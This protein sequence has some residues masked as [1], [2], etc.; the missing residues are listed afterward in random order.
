MVSVIIPSCNDPYLQKTID[1]IRS[2]AEGKIEIIVIL[3][4]VWAEV[5]ADK[6]LF[7]EERIGMRDSINLGVKESTGEYIMKIDAHCMV[8]QGWD[9]KLLIDI[10][11]NWIVVPRRYKLDVENWKIIDEPPIDYEKMTITPEKITGVYW[12]SR[13]LQRA[14]ILIDETM[15][16]QG[17]CYLMSRNHWNWLG[18]LDSKNYGTLM[19]EATEICLKTWLG[20]GKVM[21]NKH[22]WYAHKHRKFGRTYKTTDSEKSYAYARDFWLNDR[23]DKRIYDF[24]WYMNR[25]GLNL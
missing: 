13:R 4:G 11:D 15:T 16:I 8:G 21:V 22:T 1:D 5:N 3:D 12:T 18:E 23:W 10:Q 14:D 20:G 9:K 7:N 2:K 24:R 19:Q 17:S 25:F 6:V